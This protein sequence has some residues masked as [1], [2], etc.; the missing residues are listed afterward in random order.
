[1]ND[2]LCRSKVDLIIEKEQTE[3]TQNMN[4][5]MA[6]HIIGYPTLEKSY[7]VV[8]TYIDSGIEILELQ[9]PFSH[10]TADGITLTEANQQAVENG[11]SLENCFEFYEEIKRYAPDTPIIAMSYL[12]RLFSYG[13]E[14]FC[15]KLSTSG[16]N[17]IIVP[18]LPFDSPVAEQ[19]N[20]HQAVQLVPV[21]APNLNDERLSAMLNLQPDY[22]YMMSG[23]N[24]TGQQFE[25]HPNA[26]KIIDAIR[27]RTNAK[28]GIG[29]G[30][31]RGEQV[32]AVNEIADF[33]IIG[34]TLKIAIDENK[35]KSKLDQ[36]LLNS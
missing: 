12:N 17:Q 14:A 9:I 22:I 20:K 27:E 24:T 26:Q 32:K 2:E 36:L 31:S 4:S 13:I 10:P 29:F 18:D 8:Q 16:V 33:A 28:I 30:I 3:M 19:I 15:D 34:S 6:H 1:M 7:E 23:F 25:L 21:I 5:I 35:I 11:I